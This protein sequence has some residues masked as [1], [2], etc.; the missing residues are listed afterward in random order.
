MA[1][2]DADRILARAAGLGVALFWVGVFAG[3][4]LIPGYRA[5]ADYISAIASR[6]S[7]AAP[8]GIA[9]IA[10]MAL[11]YLAAGGLV[12]RTWGRASLAA[13]LA[14]AGAAQLVVAAFRIRCPLGA[15]GCR[16]EAVPVVHDAFDALHRD[17]VLAFEAFLLVAMLI[18]A[19][20]AMR[21]AP[22]PR[23]LGIV[24]VPLGILS[25]YL[26]ARTGG[27]DNGLWQR[28][29]AAVNSAWLLTVV[30]ASAGWRGRGRAR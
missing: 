9:A 19:V 28:S 12:R 20:G 3:G 8:I 25:V 1:R 14:L 6:G 4:A 30:G 24:S 21:A 23:W 17:G 15:A 22:W 26:L 11:A 5:R 13:A 16:F 27:V 29:W 18:L 10:S 7:P 2:L